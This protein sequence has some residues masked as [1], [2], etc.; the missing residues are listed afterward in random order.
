MGTWREQEEVASYTLHDPA[1]FA[2]S[3]TH[4]GAFYHQIHVLR[5]LCQ[6]K[7]R[8]SKFCV[9]VKFVYTSALSRHACLRRRVAICKTKK[10]ISWFNMQRV[11]GATLVNSIL[12]RK[13]KSK[14]ILTNCRI[15]TQNIGQAC[16]EVNDSY[17]KRIL[18]LL[19]RKRSRLRPSSSMKTLRV[20]N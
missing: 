17:P 16:G 19:G 4:F 7:S 20:K 2:V 12:Y 13:M 9:R 1:P 15:Q 8:M 3:K 14:P 6:K 5:I 18:P 11:K 10:E